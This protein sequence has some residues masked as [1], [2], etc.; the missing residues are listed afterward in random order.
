MT[1]LLFCMNIV[2]QEQ[3]IFIHDAIL[4]A[5]TCGDTQISA[6]NLRRSI[7]KLSYSDPETNYI[8]F[9]SQFKAY[10][11]VVASSAVT[12]NAQQCINKYTMLICTCIIILYIH[13]RT[14]TQ[15][16]IYMH[17]D[18]LTHLYWL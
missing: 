1:S 17:E 18:T 14:H 9:E 12:L 4:E 13:M 10:I 7:Q 6:S 8:G 16:H 2:M 5:V 15:T 3:Y 11:S